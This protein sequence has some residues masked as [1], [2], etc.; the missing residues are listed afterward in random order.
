[1]H[2]GRDAVKYL[3]FGRDDGS[4]GGTRV[5]GELLSC[6][7]AYNKSNNCL[8]PFADLKDLSHLH[9]P[10]KIIVEGLRLVL[11]ELLQLPTS[12]HN[13]NDP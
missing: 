1:M 4:E 12:L 11:G 2:G 3:F 5:Y 9:E 6:V 8:L 7:R 10:H 13:E